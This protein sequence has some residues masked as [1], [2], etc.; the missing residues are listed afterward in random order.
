MLLA[1]WPLP[2][3]AAPAAKAEASPAGVAPAAS[4]PS[5]SPRRF[6]YQGRIITLRSGRLPEVT[7]LEGC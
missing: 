7:G 5:P 3:D 1:A 6:T 4:A 2:G